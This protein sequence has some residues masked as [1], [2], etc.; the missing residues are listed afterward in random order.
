VRVSD[1]FGA[2]HFDRRVSH[3]VFM[4]MGE[5]M[6][7]LR[8]V[9]AAQRALTEDLGISARRQTI[10]TVGVP[11]TLARLAAAELPVTLAVSLHAP[12][13][14]LRESIIPSAKAYPLAALL[15]DCAAYQAA[16]GRRISFEYT[17]LENV[18]DSPAHATELGSVLSRY[19]LQGHVNVIPYNPVDGAAFSRPSGNAV[20]RFTAALSASGCGS[21][22]RRTRGADSAA[23]CGQLR[24]K[25]QSG[26]ERAPAPR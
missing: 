19:G 21:S 22:I 9:L 10:S 23:A 5:P 13:Q 18:N 8:N 12:N 24:N 26:S 7:N 17:L 16:T 25:F 3:I 4:G 11:N 15:E 14:R 1:T 20:H 2:Q 6:L